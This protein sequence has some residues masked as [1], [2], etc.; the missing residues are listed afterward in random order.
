MGVVG[1]V[2]SAI[3]AFFVNGLYYSYVGNEWAIL[4]WGKD[5][6]E[7]HGGANNNSPLPHIVT[8]ASYIALAAIYDRLIFP[9]LQVEDKMTVA[10]SL[11]VFNTLITAV[12]SLQHYVWDVVPFNNR[13]YVWA[14][15]IVSMFSVHA[16]IVVGLLLLRKWN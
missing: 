6:K 9:I 1:I 14:I 7:K 8:F 13:I 15:D 11:A 16:I 10:L 4:R 12:T 2:T 3:V 5:Y